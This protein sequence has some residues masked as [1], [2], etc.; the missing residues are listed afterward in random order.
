MHLFSVLRRNIKEYW[1][2]KW[3]EIN[4]EGSHEIAGWMREDMM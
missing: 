1:S 3:M 4:L 2:A